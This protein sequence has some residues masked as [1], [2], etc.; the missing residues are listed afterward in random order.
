MDGPEHSPGERQHRGPGSAAIDATLASA[1]RKRQLTEELDE[2]LR[3]Q[4][5][6]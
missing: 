4:G 1:D 6:S 2:M 5:S 3:T